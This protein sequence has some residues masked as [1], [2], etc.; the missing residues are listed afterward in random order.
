MNMFR[1]QK[2]TRVAACMLI[3]GTATLQAQEKKPQLNVVKGPTNAQ[4]GSH[5]QLEVPAGYVFLD[6][7]NYRKLL[8][9]EGEPV[10]GGEVGW[11]KPTNQEWAVVFQF[12]DV[13]YVKDD[14]KDKLDADKLLDTIKRGTAEAN[15]TRAKAG[16]PPIE[17]VGW[18][19]RP[20]Y[21]ETT[22]NLE[23]A[24]RGQCEGRQIL[25]YNTR[26]LG[27]KGVMGVVLIVEP[28]N[29]AETLPT[30]RSLLTKYSYTTG[31]TYA[32]YKSG[33]KVAKYGLGALVVGGAAVGAAKL[34]LFAWVA[35]LLKKAGKA[36]I[37]A[38]VAV[39]AFFKK[40]LGRLFGGRTEPG[41]GPSA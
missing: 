36:V 20:K 33:D 3:L 2:L 35:V 21:D 39:V 27:R 11:L 13:G 4:L 31:E 37:L 29:L 34:G 24:I 41:G 19:V 15:K 26:L 7:N 10:S 30:L 16:N 8:K 17:V 9:A 5:A 38:V 32:E 22:H 18:D 1:M 6:G 14:D 23:W 28:E 40:L 12:S 25:N